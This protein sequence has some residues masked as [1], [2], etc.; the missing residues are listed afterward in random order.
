MLCALST[1]FRADLIWRNNIRPKIAPQCKRCHPCT[2]FTDVNPYNL[3]RDELDN[4]DDWKLIGDPITSEEALPQAGQE[5]GLAVDFYGNI[6]VVGV[7][8]RHQVDL[9]QWDGVEQQWQRY[10]EPLQ[11]IEGSNFGFSVQYRGS[12]LVVG[13]AITDDENAGMVD[14]YQRS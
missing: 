6:L 8:G 1:H 11:G 7:P 4:N 3:A 14:V 5:L 12:S 13:S 9:F 10:P 2:C